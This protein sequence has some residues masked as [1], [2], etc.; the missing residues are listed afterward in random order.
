[1]NLAIRTPRPSNFCI[2][3]MHKQFKTIYIRSNNDTYT[4]TAQK[5][6]NNINM[7]QAHKGIHAALPCKRQH[8]P[9]E[10]YIISSHK[11]ARDRRHG[12][13]TVEPRRLTSC[14]VQNV[15]SVGSN[16]QKVV[17]VELNVKN[18]VT[19]GSNVTKVVTVGST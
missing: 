11:A 10:N 1:M 13:I 6:T 8:A 19:V 14:N 17:A 18:V 7:K 2:T 3:N 5:A 16:V 12:L 9:Q 4:Q 15:V